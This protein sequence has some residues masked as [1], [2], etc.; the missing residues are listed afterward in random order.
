VQNALHEQA[1]LNYRSVVLTALQEVEDS[2]VAFGHE[3][4]R[5]QLLIQSVAA[6]RRAVELATQRYNAGLTDFLSVLDAE[7]SLFAAEDQLV[8]S[9]RVVSDDL[10]ALYKALGGGW[11]VTDERPQQ[12][13]GR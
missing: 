4:V 9:D 11:E 8:Q 2:I 10:V 13:L 1:L 3:Q 5:R 12:A 6:N 7:R